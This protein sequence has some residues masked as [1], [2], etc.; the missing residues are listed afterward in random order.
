MGSKR[1]CYL[2][3]ARLLIAIGIMLLAGAEAA[4]RA[5]AQTSPATPAPGTGSVEITQPDNAKTFHV[6]VGQTVTVR[7]GTDLDWTVTVAPP[8]ILP[9]VPGVNTLVRG[10]QAIYRAAQPGTATVSAEGRAHCDPGQACPQ[11]IVSVKATVVVDAGASTGTG[12]AAPTRTPT[13]AQRP[14]APSTTAPG[15]ASSRPATIAALPNTGTRTLSSKGTTRGMGT[16]AILLV[17]SA[18]VGAGTIMWR[19]RRSS[20]G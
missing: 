17:C 4:D 5:S 20:E 12:T 14:T 15:A 2:S 13:S 3:Y 19:A 11:F 8:G 10:V 6:S 1:H 7:L 18:L 16:F 9:L